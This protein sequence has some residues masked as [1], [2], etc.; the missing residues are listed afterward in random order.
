MRYKK[1]PFYVVH[2]A[3]GKVVAGAEYREDAR[4]MA[5]DMPLPASEYSVLTHTGVVRKYGSVSWGYPPG[6]RFL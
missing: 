6:V 4:D 3:S 2:K 5:N 1:Y